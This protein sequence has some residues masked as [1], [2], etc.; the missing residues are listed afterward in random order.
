MRLPANIG[1]LFKSKKNHLLPD[2]F[3]DYILD[4]SVGH[5]ACYDAENYRH[6]LL[7]CDSK[8]QITDFGA[9]S[10]KLGNKT[11]IVKDIA[12]VSGTKPEFGM[13]FTKLINAFGVKNILEMGTSVGIGT[14][15]L[16]QA[17]PE[18]G[19]IG[20]EAC[21]QTADFLK[22][23][24]VENK[25]SN[26]EIINDDFDSVF[27]KGVLAQNHFDLVYI[28]GNHRGEALLKYYEI[29]KSKYLNKQHIIIADDINW[30]KD[31]FA[32]WKR[33]T[34]SATDTYLDLFR[35]GIILSGYDLPQGLFSINFQYQPTKNKI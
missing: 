12:A 22:N 18:I 33:I 31:M 26:V 3:N 2:V 9:G 21:P 13:F 23:K 11:R 14:F 27:E 5:Y 25:I 29:L 19:L 34:S 30:S 17:A 20:I 10:H 24:L 16:S 28:D 8:L 6:E 4:M 1:Y 7:K 15:Y 32:A 35:C